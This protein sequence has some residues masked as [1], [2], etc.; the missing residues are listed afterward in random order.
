MGGCRV[1]GG[2]RQ[3]KILGS[4]VE[5]IGRATFDEGDGLER[6][7][8]G[9]EIGNALAIAVACEQSPADVGNDDDARVGALDE[10]ASSDLC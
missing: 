3:R 8:R 6:F 9:P 1:V 2:T 5:R 4:K 10:L 7:R